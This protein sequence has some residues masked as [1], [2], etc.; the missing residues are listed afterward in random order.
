MGHS[1]GLHVHQAAQNAITA[2][3]TDLLALPVP[4]LTHVMAAP[5]APATTAFVPVVDVQEDQA[6][7]LEPYL[8][9]I[10]CDFSDLPVCNSSSQRVSSSVSSF[11]M[12]SGCRIGNLPLTSIS[13]QV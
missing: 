9:D 11:G 5:P 13:R 8:Q 7:A 3:S 4:T 1:I 6:R 10:L 2:P 12:F